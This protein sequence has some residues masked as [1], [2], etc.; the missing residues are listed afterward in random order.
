MTFLTHPNF[1]EPDLS[2]R[3]K[4]F[5]ILRDEVV[6]HWE[7]AARASIEGAQGIPGP[8]LTGSFPAFFDHIAEALSPQY[9][10]E[11][12]TSDNI[13]AAAHGR[14]RARMTDYRV[15]QIAEE[16]QLFQASIDAVAKGRMEF[17]CRDWEVINRSINLATVE[18][19][20]AFMAAT[21]AYRT[22]AAATLTH[23][24]RTPLSVIGSAAELIGVARDLEMA[25][26]AGAKISSNV[27]RLDAMTTELIDALVHRKTS[28]TTLHLTQFDM[29]NLVGEVRE[30]YANHRGRKL[31]L[32]SVGESVIGFWC[33][34]SIR[35]ALENLINNAI[36]Y[37]DAGK[38]RIKAGENRGRLTLSVKNWGQ[39]IPKDKQQRIFKYLKREGNTVTAFGWGIG[40]PF[41]K[42][43]AESHGGTVAVDSSA[44]TGTTFLIDIPVDCRP[45][46]ET[47]RFV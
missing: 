6:D 2:P 9:P 18:S 46:A 13:G 3:A 16:Y 37:G 24:M 8:V 47:P 26:K 35:R 45:Y 25:R 31:E 40:L 22:Q 38:V 34:D 17:Y 33:K 21:E 20:R 43:I 1:D 42:S 23:D 41:V 10:R 29:L 4:Q 7:Q 27:R 39:P 30:Q 44:M 32:Q 5:L 28:G 11:D 14:E 15:D 36:K 19:I 12:A